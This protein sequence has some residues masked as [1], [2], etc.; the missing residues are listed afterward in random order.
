LMLGPRITHVISV[1]L[2]GSQFYIFDWVVKGKTQDPSRV[3]LFAVS[4]SRTFDARS[5]THPRKCLYGY[6]SQFYIFDWVVK[7]KTQDPS[8]VLLFAVS[9]R[10]CLY[11]Y[12]SQFY[13]FDWV[14]KGKTHTQSKGRP[15][16]QVEY[17]CS[18]LVV[19]ELLMLG[20]RL[21]HGN[22][23]MATW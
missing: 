8:R 21:T 12:G 9:P 5:K 6:G 14:V 7:G 1:W 16:T 2:H 23:C 19:R 18:L 3:L 17:C 22:V 10:K 11:G 4:C 20:P 15:K 13:I